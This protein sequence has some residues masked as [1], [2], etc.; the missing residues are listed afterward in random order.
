MAS[1]TSKSRPGLSFGGTVMECT[2]FPVPEKYWTTHYGAVEPGSTIEHNHECPVHGSD[3]TNAWEG[4][5]N[6]VLGFDPA[7]SAED[8]VMA[9]FHQGY[10]STLKMGMDLENVDWAAINQSPVWV[11]PEPVEQALSFRVDY[12][13]PNLPPLLNK[14]QKGL[15]GKAYRAYRRRH[16]RLRQ[17]WKK[18]G[19]PT[20]SMSFYMPRVEVTFDEISQTMTAVATSAAKTADSMRKFADAFAMHP[21]N[22]KFDG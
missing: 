11:K 19:C 13:E 14:R 1:T 17:Q 15:G 7:G 21:S 4:V 20:R 12:E 5:G 2:C 10:V 6:V 16:R 8:M 3:E 18:D 9:K 22:W